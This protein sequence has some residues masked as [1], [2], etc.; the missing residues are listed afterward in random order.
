MCT[1]AEKR[2]R[3]YLISASHLKNA[4][5]VKKTQVKLVKKRKKKE[6]EKEK[7][8]FILL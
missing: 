8:L 3:Y 1:E 6:K 4:L 5:K 2:E 7:R